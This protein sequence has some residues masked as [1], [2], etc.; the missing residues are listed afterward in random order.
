MS[1]TRTILRFAA[2]VPAIDRFDR[3]LFIGPH[4]DDIEIGA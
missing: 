2:P 1:L 3:Y 4:A